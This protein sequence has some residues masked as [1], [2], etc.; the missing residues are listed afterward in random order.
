MRGAC[1]ALI[2]CASSAA[3]ADERFIQGVVGYSDPM[4]GYAQQGGARIGLRVGQ[5]PI[6]LGDSRFGVEAGVDW[7]HLRPMYSNVDE[8]RVLAGARLVFPSDRAEVF[9]R[10]DIGFDSLDVDNGGSSANGYAFEPGFGAAFRD[11][12]LRFGAEVAVPIIWH[13]ASDGERD[14]F[15]ADLQ[16]AASVGSVF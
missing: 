3:H 15:G 10:A 9:F 11:G 1:I 12:N 5:T 4:S 2:V 16:L 6:E 13:T 7:R 8:L 14:L